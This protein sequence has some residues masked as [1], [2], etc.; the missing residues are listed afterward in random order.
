VVTVLATGPTVAGS[1][2]AEDGGFLWVIKVHSVHLLRREVKPSVPRRRFA[3]RKR[4]LQSMSEMLFS[5]KF[6]QPY[7]LT[8]NLLLRYQMALVV[9]SG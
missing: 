9:E 7:F 6:P 5:A 2:P 4:T 8:A 3:A 1:G